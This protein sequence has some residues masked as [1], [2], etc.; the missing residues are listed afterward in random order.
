[1]RKTCTRV[2]KSRDIGAPPK[3]LYQ[4]EHSCRRRISSAKTRACCARILYRDRRRRE[5]PLTDPKAAVHGRQR[6]V[7][8]GLKL[9]IFGH[10]SLTGSCRPTG[11]LRGASTAFLKAVIHRA[12][13]SIRATLQRCDA[14]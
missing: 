7:R 8:S 5:A 14:M 13:R 11:D 1:M 6:R 4:Y 10:R 9:R 3:N 12:G 2:I